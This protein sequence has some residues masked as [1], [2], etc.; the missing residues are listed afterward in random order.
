V[1]KNFKQMPSQF[2]RTSQVKVLSSAFKGIC[3]P[4]LASSVFVFAALPPAYSAAIYSFR[5]NTRETT[6]TR[7]FVEGGIK[8]TVNNAQGNNILSALSNDGTSGG[9]N[10]D[11]NNGLC[12][13]LFAGFNTGK[14]QYTSSSVGDPTLTGLTFTFD[15]PVFLKGFDVLRMGGVESGRLTFTSA[16][17]TQTFDFLN[18]GGAAMANGV[19]FNS[20]AFNDNFIVEAGA[21]LT[22]S[23]LGT[24]FSVGQAGSIR[25][26]NFMVEEVP[27]PLPV[28][29]FAGAF[30]WSRRLRKKLAK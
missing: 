20:F 4:V 16:S 21:P 15:K 9:V 3:A 5:T 11:I 18:P 6:I 22:V 1:R 17:S 10:T 26:S 30:G 19:V 2:L 27:T 14:C 23:S 13:A 7:D 12:V 8:L 25:M 24:I 28:L 29:S